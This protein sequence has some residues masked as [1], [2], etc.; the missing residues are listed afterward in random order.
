MKVLMNNSEH[1]DNLKY[2]SYSCLYY[3]DNDN[4]FVPIYMYSLKQPTKILFPSN[5]SKLISII[6]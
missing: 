3:P 1:H 2:K 6:S 4:H 5:M